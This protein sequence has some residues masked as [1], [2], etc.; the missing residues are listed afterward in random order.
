MKHIRC[1]L[2]IMSE[3]KWSARLQCIKPFASHLNCV[4]LGL[5]DLLG[6][7]ELNLIARNEV[8]GA[9]AYPL[10]FICMLTSADW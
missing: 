6:L 3:T 4:Q 7:L 1:S 5:L 2:H 9:L 10:T 8:N